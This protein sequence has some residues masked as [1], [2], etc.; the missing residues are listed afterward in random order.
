MR[1][2]LVIVLILAGAKPFWTVWRDQEERLALATQIYERTQIS[3]QH[4]DMMKDQYRDM[5][6][7]FIHRADLAEYIHTLVKEHAGHVA[8]LRIVEHDG[9]AEAHGTLELPAAGLLSALQ[10]L[11]NDTPRIMFQELDLQ[12]NDAGAVVVKFIL[13]EF[14][15]GAEQ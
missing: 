13:A 2:V 10:A 4:Q 11:E 3:A 14:T 8:D 1:I 7:P 6:Q 5:L 15:M 12:Q 9:H